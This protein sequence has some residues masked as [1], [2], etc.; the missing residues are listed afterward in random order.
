MYLPDERNVLLPVFQYSNVGGRS[1]QNL[2][3]NFGLPI[4]ANK[5]DNILFINERICLLPK[6]SLA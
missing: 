6:N 3:D 5:R 4:K 1:K 2:L